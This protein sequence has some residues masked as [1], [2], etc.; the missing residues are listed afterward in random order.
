MY[1]KAYTMYAKGKLP[2]PPL[3]LA[4]TCMLVKWTVIITQTPLHTYYFMWVVYVSGIPSW[5]WCKCKRPNDV[6]G[7]WKDL[8][9][10]AYFISQISNLVR[11]WS[12]HTTTRTSYTYIFNNEKAH[13]ITARFAPTFLFFFILFIYLFF[14]TFRAHAA[15]SWHAMT[16]SQLFKGLA[17]LGNIVAETM[18]LVMFP[19]VA[20]LGNI[21]FGRKICIW[22]TKMFLTPGKNIF[23]FRAAKFVSATHISRAGNWETVAFATMFPPQCFLV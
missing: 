20:K 21:C 2:P 7:D 19:G 3:F 1:A 16:W 23:R 5:L 9:T 11:R 15:Y 17:K 4:S 6:N 22:E 13:S 14:C 8:I 18:F 10:K 12:N